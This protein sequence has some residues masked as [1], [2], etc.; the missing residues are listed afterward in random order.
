MTADGRFVI[1][2]SSKAANEVS[3]GESSARDISVFR[4]DL[5]TGATDTYTTRVTGL[6]GPFDDVEVLADGRVLLTQAGQNGGGTFPLVTLDLVTGTFASAG[7]EALP[8]YVNVSASAGG[9]YNLVSGGI[10]PGRIALLDANGTLLATR[11]PLADAIPAFKNG[12][13][14][15]SSTGQVLLGTDDALNLYDVRLALQRDILPELREQ[16][17]AGQF[18][19]IAFSA[20]GSR[21]YGANPATNAVYEVATANWTVT[22]A[23]AVGT[24]IPGEFFSNADPLVLAPDGRTLLV[25]GTLIDLGTDNRIIAGD[26][27]GQ[28]V[29]TD[30]PDFL[31]GGA[32]RDRIDGGLGSDTL[33]GGAGDDTYVISAQAPSG[34]LSPP[35][36][37]I[38]RAGE[39]QDEVI[40]SVDYRLPDNVETLRLA[41][42]AIATIT[43]GD[44]GGT[45]IGNEL[46]TLL[47]G[48][49]GNDVFV[50]GKG[51]DTFQSN[52]KGVDTAVFAD[53]IADARLELVK[54]TIYRGTQYHLYVES[55][56]GRDDAGVIGNSFGSSG[57]ISRLQFDDGVIETRSLVAVDQ[58]Y[59]SYVGRA[60]TNSELVT[61]AVALGS[62]GDPRQ[63]L[64][65][66]ATFG[67]AVGNRID[68]AY[69]RF[70]GRD[71]TADEIA[72]W[73]GKLFYE[74]YS[75]RA[76]EQVVINAPLTADA[77]G[78]VY[79]S[80]FGRAAST[81]EIETWRSLFSQGADLNTVRSTIQAEID[82]RNAPLNAQIDALYRDYGGRSANPEELAFW[83]EQVEGGAPVG[84]IKSAILADPLSVAA[85]G[86]TYLDLF[87]RAATAQEVATWRSLFG[88]GRDLGDL[89]AEILADPAGR[90][91]TGA[92]IVDAYQDLFGRAPT[93]QEAAT[94]QDLFRA[95]KDAGDLRAA[96]LAEPAGQANVRS[97]IADAYQDLGGRAPT[98][99]EVAT[100]LDAFRGGADATSLRGAILDDQVLGASA[101]GEIADAYQD[102][103][104]RAASADETATWLALFRSGTETD[105]LIDTLFTHPQARANGVLE[106]FGTANAD[107][108]A[109]G[110]AE[111]LLIRGFDPAQDLIDLRGSPLAGSNP[112]AFA[113]EVT[114]L[115]GRIDVLIDTLSHDLLFT[116][117]RLDQL[118]TSD[119]LV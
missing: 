34:T 33:A 76:F 87:G 38:E 62:A 83:R 71:A 7:T 91:Y 45:L 99:A 114:A 82:T 53:T 108:F 61:L 104:G 68:Q 2:T 25:Q 90:A 116:G 95:G 60:P 100:W 67:S 29:G 119:F 40:T 110:G 42:G 88:D 111:D 94:W 51:N 57:G 89:R 16:L 44:Q 63:A 105:T 112:L 22:N 78:H 55:A 26:G 113:H 18:S 69:E 11:E 52:G 64:F 46:G 9:T 115:D 12:L 5:T 96:I 81:A 3:S 93:P 23:W 97:V 98:E 117:L 70:A 8:A 19:A 41:A 21:L 66:N 77:I 31:Q 103:F 54:Q 1:A 28:L 37:I 47:V 118:S 20:D 15:V 27:G 6:A 79:G 36:V 74:N 14:A 84:A 13:A 10:Y 92:V 107:S 106:V 86:D 73:K 32:G 24:T 72:V 65:E 17:G 39:G 101:R 4:Y 48:G 35:D 102:H 80:L 109:L 43:G 85:I 49:A 58:G 30:Q 56:D 50:G 59:A 75:L